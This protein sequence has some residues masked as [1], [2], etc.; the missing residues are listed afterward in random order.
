MSRN[1]IITGANGGLGGAVVG[2]FLDDQYTVI[3]V[4][5]SENRNTA[6]LQDPHFEHHVVN[7][8]DESET[9]DLIATMISKHQ[10]IHAAL[11]LVGGFEMGDIASTD[12]QALQKMIS[13]NFET[14]YFAAR[15]L[16]TH[17]LQQGY[18]RIV[19]IGARPA[20]QA[21][22]GKNVVAYALSKSLLFKLAELL[23]ETA[24]GTNVVVSVVAPSTIDTGANRKSMPD[25][26]TAKWVK[27]AQI[28]DLLA[29]ICSEK[30]DAL[31]EPV[32]K[33]YHQA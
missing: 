25:A 31:R 22:A 7:L 11:L 3:A 21:A 29:F 19:L 6:A 15:P 5:H 1:I 20:L 28:A 30:G 16:F 24:K 8:Q 10:Q 32:Y 18:G 13:L 4:D 2:K 14:A 17:M 33:I 26:D 12:G 23:N 9:G 27:P